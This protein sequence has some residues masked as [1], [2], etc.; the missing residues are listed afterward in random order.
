MNTVEPIRDLE[1]LWEF[2]DKMKEYGEREHMIFLFGVYTGLR[3]SDILKLKV[4]DVKNRGVITIKE[5]KTKKIKTF[6]INPIV[7]SELKKY[8]VNKDSNDFLF[9]SRQKRKEVSEAKTFDSKGQRKDY[10]KKN[11]D[12]LTRQR[13][14]QILKK[15]SK[16]LG[17]PNIGCHTLRK[18][19]GYHYYTTKKDIVKLMKIFNHSQESITLRYIGY[20]QETINEAINSMDFRR[21]KC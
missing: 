3:I 4:K 13:V 20:E 5:Q 10:R 18:T 19:F 6:A 2:E 12:V 21:K 1:T 16:D 8:L 14:W 7:Q 9:Q 15:V 17:V 11:N